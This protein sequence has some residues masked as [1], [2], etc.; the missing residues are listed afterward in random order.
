MNE[1]LKRLFDEAVK[2]ERAKQIAKGYT[3]EHDDA[4]GYSH[5]YSIFK[6]AV[7]QRNWVSADA[8][9]IA[10]TAYDERRVAQGSYGDGWG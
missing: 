7:M 8:M 6:D 4:H 10:M 2:D 5:L 3:A 1:V 9:R